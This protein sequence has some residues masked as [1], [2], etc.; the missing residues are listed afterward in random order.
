M[1]CFA[2]VLHSD[3][4]LGAVPIFDG[5]AQPFTLSSYQTL[6]RHGTE[7]A[8]NSVAMVTFTVGGYELPPAKIPDGAMPGMNMR[9]SLN[10]KNVVFLADSTIPYSSRL[11]IG[12][13]FWG[14]EYQKKSGWSMK[15]T[16]DSDSLAAEVGDVDGMDEQVI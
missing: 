13:E 11:P 15:P 12:E 4:I 2:F 16:S 14:V 3:L 9:A 8:L 6:P 1:S 10:I 5:R 7:L